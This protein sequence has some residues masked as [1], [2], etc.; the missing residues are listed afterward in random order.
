MFPF[1]QSLKSSYIVVW[2]PIILKVRCTLLSFQ[3]FSIITS[4]YLMFWGPLF[5]VTLLHPHWEWKDAKQ[6]MLHEVTV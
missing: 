5:L 2:G 3:I 6:S 4:A 1:S